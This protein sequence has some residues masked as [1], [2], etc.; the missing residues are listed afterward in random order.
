MVGHTAPSDQGFPKRYRLRTRAEFERVFQEGWVASDRTLVVHAVR[1]G[2]AYAR[3]GLSVSKR[4]GNAPTRNRWKRWIRESF[5][6]H[7]QQLPSG[8]DIIVRPRRDAVADFQAVVQSLRRL[9][10]QC[11]RKLSAP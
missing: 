11:D 7:R 2:L 6:Q 10:Q 5:R 9:S 3:L 4:V 1:N 8:L